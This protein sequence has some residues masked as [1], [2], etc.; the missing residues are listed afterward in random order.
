MPAS[1]RAHVVAIDVAAAARPIW[2]ELA[3][4]S[5]LRVTV[6]DCREATREVLRDAQPDIVLL[7]WS[8]GRDPSGWPL[9]NALSLDAGLQRVPV[10]I[11]TDIPVENLEAADERVRFLPK[12]FGFNALIDVI[13]AT[14]GTDRPVPLAGS[15]PDAA[16]PS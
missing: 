12:P 7:D 8:V 5:S 11:L 6:Y 10:V 4:Q 1:R 13:S 3:A 16:T 2:R 14:L 9:L 15:N